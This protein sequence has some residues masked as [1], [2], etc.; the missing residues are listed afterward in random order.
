MPIYLTGKGESHPVYFG[1]STTS[2]YFG[3]FIKGKEGGR[4]WNLDE[5][6]GT[7]KAGPNPSKVKNPDNVVG[8]IPDHT[9]GDPMVIPTPQFPSLVRL[10]KWLR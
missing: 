3:A 9:H 8:L 7:P 4:Q 2:L 10:S 1:P 5:K 6:G